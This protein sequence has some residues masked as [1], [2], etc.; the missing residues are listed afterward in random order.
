MLKRSDSQAKTQLVYDP[1]S[2]LTC[3]R[4]SMWVL[5]ELVPIYRSR[6]PKIA[7]VRDVRSETLWEAII[8]KSQI[9][10]CN[11]CRVSEQCVRSMWICEGAARLFPRRIPRS[12]T[13]S[14]LHK[15]A[16][17]SS[18]LSHDTS[19]FLVNSFRKS[20]AHRRLPYIASLLL[21]HPFSLRGNISHLRNLFLTFRSIR[22]RDTINESRFS[23]PRTVARC[24]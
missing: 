2:K 24:A 22:S 23:L 17:V 8:E 1:R 11:C 12:Y 3:E 20:L 10:I 15:G 4:L 18:P 7:R 19:F 21:A 13:A 6:A 9:A 14:W 16:P 5:R